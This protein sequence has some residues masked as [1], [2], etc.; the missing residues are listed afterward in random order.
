MNFAELEIA[1]GGVVHRLKFTTKKSMEEYI[2]ELTRVYIEKTHCG[3]TGE[4]C[5]TCEVGAA[6][7]DVDDPEGDPGLI[8]IDRAMN[9]GY[10]FATDTRIMR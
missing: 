7:K 10:K 9:I 6:H 1:V 5:H 8:Y 3:E 2:N 4:V